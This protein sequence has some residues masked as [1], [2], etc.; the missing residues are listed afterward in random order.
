MKRILF[1][2]LTILLTASCNKNSTE[3]VTAEQKDVLEFVHT[4]LEKNHKN[5]YAQ[6]TKEEFEEKKTEIKS[7]IED[8]EEPREIY[9]G[10]LELVAFV[11]DSHTRGA[12]TN[13]D[14]DYFLYNMVYYE[15]GWRLSAIDN[16]NKEFLGQKVLGFNELNMEEFENLG[17]KLVSHDNEVQ[18]RLSMPNIVNT[19]SAFE[20]L[21]IIEKGE[22]LYINLEDDNGN[23]SKVKLIVDNNPK[24]KFVGDTPNNTLSTSPSGYYRSFDIDENNLFIQYNVCANDKDYPMS[25][26]SKDIEGFLE[27]YEFKNIIIDLRY[28]S[29]GDSRVLDPFIGMLKKNREGRNFFGLIG[30]ST[31]SSAILNAIELKNSLDA[32]LVGSPT[33]GSINHYG[34]VRMLEI[35]NT[36]FQISYSTKY[37]EINPELGIEPLNPDIEIPRVYKNYKMGIDPEVKYILENY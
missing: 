36:P 23:H 33:G 8:F 12:Y 1:V 37:F 16:E 34:E 27:K 14:L 5:M 11:G 3:L 35:P 18:L 13:A 9:N 29:G 26:F 22:D 7:K 32:T 31:F 10:I 24:G 30:P 2:L 17:K 6:I 25:K 20:Y 28:N 4:N 19:K 21:G 15:D